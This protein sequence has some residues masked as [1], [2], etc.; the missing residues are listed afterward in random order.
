MSFFL[1]NRG[2]KRD[3]KGSKRGGF[4]V[5]SKKPK[6]SKTATSKP[7]KVR[8][9]EISSEE[10]EDIFND[11]RNARIKEVDDDDYEDAPTRAYREAKALLEKVKVRYLLYI[12]FK[13]SV[14]VFMLLFNF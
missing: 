4:D 7:K 5:K 9:D 8:E 10:D 6:L 11:A 3:N 12:Y 13:E 2:G 1:R 14:A